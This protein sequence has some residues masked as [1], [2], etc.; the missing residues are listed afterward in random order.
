MSDL[1]LSLASAIQRG[2]K[3]HLR[4]ALENGFNSELLEGDGKKAY[5]YIVDFYKKHSDIPSP[6][7]VMAETGVLLTPTSEPVTYLIDAL[8][9]RKLHKV[10]H[11]GVKEVIDHLGHKRP[12]KGRATL[13]ELL[14]TIRKMD[15]RTALVESL[16]G[17]GQQVLDYYEKIKRGER[18]ILTPW[19]SINES[20]MGFWPEDL[21]LFAA[22]LGQGKTWVLLQLAG[23]AWE[24]GKKVLVVTT[25]MAKE[26]LAMRYFA[27]KLKLPY[28]QLRKGRLDIFSEKKFYDGVKSLMTSPNFSV[29]GGD[30]DFSMEAFAGIVQ[31]EKPD[32]VFVD[33]AYLLKVPGLTRTEKAANV[34][35][36][37]KRVA[38]RAKC[39]VVATTQ[40]NREVKQNQ[41]KTVQS[42]SIALTDVAGW[43]ADLMF[44]LIQTEEMKQNKRMAFKPL[45][46][47]E[48]AGEEIECNWDFDRM[49]FSELPKANQSGAA[50]NIVPS[51]IP[52][53]DA[54]LF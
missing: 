8:F 47:R 41:A 21:V 7:V 49:D 14:R 23:C 18:G 53:N 45:K 2:G 16:P 5:E 35:D 48:G 31:D 34:F 54:D 43:N 38:K 33:G 3:Q 46:V 40:F 17:M 10:L 30:F 29:V 44:G 51:N 26:R 42:D 39:V 52:D 9:E 11:G 25:E 36:E 13:E 4:F 12:D 19:D 50:A 32:I 1:D 22:R 24:Q 27:Y 6:D 20:T 37:L 15:T 28:D